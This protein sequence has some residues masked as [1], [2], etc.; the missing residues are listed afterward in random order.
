M[1]DQFAK[2]SFDALVRTLENCSFVPETVDRTKTNNKHGSLPLCLS[3]FLSLSL[4]NVS[5][6]EEWSELT[7]ALRIHRNFERVIACRAS[8]ARG[9]IT[10]RNIYNGRRIDSRPG[11]IKFYHTGTGHHLKFNL[12]YQQRSK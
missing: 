12:F 3:D 7:R 10:T 9:L 2:R 8:I 4:R 1:L 6:I 5:F 11:F